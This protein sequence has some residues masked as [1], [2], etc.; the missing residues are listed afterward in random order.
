MGLQAI[1]CQIC[2]GDAVQVIR[3]YAAHYLR[4]GQMS[5]CIAAHI[6]LSLAAMLFSYKC[7]QRERGR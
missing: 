6:K 5:L 7:E 3:A 4:E 1:Y 2:D